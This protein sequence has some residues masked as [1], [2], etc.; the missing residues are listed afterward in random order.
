MIQRITFLAF[1][2]FGILGALEEPEV[3]PSHPESGQKVVITVDSLPLLSETPV[4]VIAAHTADTVLV[5][6]I[7]GKKEGQGFSFSYE[8]PDEASFIQYCVEDDNQSYMPDDLPFYGI[9]VYNKS[10]KPLY[11]SYRLYANLY[12]D[13]D[14][15]HLRTA[16]VLLE[17][18]LANY[19]MNWAA[20]VLLKRIDLEN[21]KTDET[22]IG[23]KLDSLLAL[24][25]DSLEALYFA[26][27]E[28][29][30][31]SATFKGKAQNLMLACAE[32][33]PESPYWT[34]YQYSLYEFI[35]SSPDNIGNYEREVFPLLKNEAKESGYF[36]LMSYA[37]A[38][39]RS[40]RIQD[41]AN[42]F[43]N[44]FPTS[45]LAPAFVVTMLGTK[46]EQP[47]SEW[48]QELEK[49]WK[50]YP[51]DPELNFQ[52]A[53]FYKERSWNTALTYY[54]N[55]LKASKTPQAAVVFAEAASEKGKNFAEASKAMR[56]AI[57]ETTQDQYRELLWWETFESRQE[58]LLQSQASLYVTQGWLDFKS[59]DYDAAMKGLL[60]ADT[61]LSKVPAYSEELYRKL[62]TVSEKAGDLEVRKMALVSL[63]IVQ[64]ED[65]ATQEAINDIYLIEHSDTTGF[66]EWF[67]DE[68]MKVA[69]RNRI[70]VTVPD[71][72]LTDLS[73]NQ[74]TLKSLQGKVVV[75]NFWAT[76]CQP[77]R[78]EMPQLNSLVKEFQG[79]SDV[80][81][82]G[83]SSED[84]KIINAFLD[85]N[86]FL[87]GIYLDNNQVAS[88]FQIQSVPT[89]LVIDKKG[90]LQFQHVGSFPSLSK[91]LSSEIDA[92][93]EDK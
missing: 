88:M 73:G 44:E 38:G 64:P 39:G 81:F 79:R 68:K 46:Y 20:F 85:N 42:S 75:I 16:Q 78:D 74:I 89:H 91:I 9:P 28:F 18:E 21:G 40:R 61:L 51:T 43:L 11:D 35:K 32:K 2:L 37:L 34:D 77:C 62:L 84:P 33:F 48:A 53:E 47:T 8:I 54:R 6:I 10:G 76:W 83:I 55:G 50:N 29:F 23:A 1:S 30:M 67:F 36:L 22:S 80:V 82:I 59:G 70:D 87:Y 65:T 14:P 26:A 92:L 56:Q 49:W 45:S 58:K 15:N 31:T 24:G 17:Q 13:F 63:L 27:M 4:V 66:G 19:P 3:V 69:L 12:L 60:K 5:D 86:T 25:P 71:F 90:K 72:G 7:R 93:L 52:L 41:I 57:T